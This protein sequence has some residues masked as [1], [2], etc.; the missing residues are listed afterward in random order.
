MR[1]AT[2][3]ATAALCAIVLLAA[4]GEVGPSPSGGDVGAPAPT[5]RLRVGLTEWEINVS[6]AEVKPGR[7]HLVVTNAGATEHDLVIVT[8]HRRVH[9]APIAP[10]RQR[11]LTLPVAGSI[12]LSSRM[13]GQLRPMHAVVRVR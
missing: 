10:G 6:S 3:W 4:C 9:L 12:D 7:L 5:H 11:A 1:R 13:P 8:G 2:R